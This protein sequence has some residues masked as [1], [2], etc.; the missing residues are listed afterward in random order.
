MRRPTFLEL[1]I[2]GAVLTLLAGI[3]FLIWLVA[4]AINISLAAVGIA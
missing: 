2:G 3:A 4:L 1:T